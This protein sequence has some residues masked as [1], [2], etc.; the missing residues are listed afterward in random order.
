MLPTVTILTFNKNIFISKKLIKIKS[1][2]KFY[3]FFVNLYLLDF[4]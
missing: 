1:Q 3:N 4:H 2:L